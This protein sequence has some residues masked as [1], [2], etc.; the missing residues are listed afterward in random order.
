MENPNNNWKIISALPI[1]LSIGTALIYL[2]YQLNNLGLFLG[3]LAGLAL[4][5]ATWRFSAW[6]WQKPVWPK[7]TAKH[8][9]WLIVYLI[10]WSWAITCLW[11]ARSSDAIIS[12]WLIVSGWFFVAWIATFVTA[13]IMAWHNH[14]LFKLILILEY[15]LA[16][17]V[18]AIIYKLGYGFDPFVHQ[19]AVDYIVKHGAVNP[20][21]FYYSGQYGLETLLTKLGLSLVLIDT[22][23]LPLSSALLLP[24]AILEAG[25]KIFHESTVIR[26][27]PLALLILPY[28][29]L[30]VTTPQNLAYLL[31]LVAIATALGATVKTDWYF[32]WLLT[33]L[34]LLLQPIAGLPLLCL[35]SAWR[36][37]QLNWKNKDIGYG[38]LLAANAVGL[39]LVFMLL[40]V[41]PVSWKMLLKGLFIWDW[42]KLVLPHQNNWLLNIIYSLGNNY[43][44][45]LL[46]LVVIGSYLIFKNGYHRARSLYGLASLHS[47]ALLIAY[48]L[49]RGLNFNYLIDYERN[50]YSSR[51]LVM[52]VI[53]SLP[54]I[55]ISFYELLKRA[56]AITKNPDRQYLFFGA[57]TLLVT[58]SL[59]L[60]YPRQDDYASSG[61]RAVSASDIEAV[62][63][64]AADSG[65]DPYVVLANQQ[66]SAAALRLYGFAHYYND[67]F[68][69]PLPTGGLLYS[70]FLKMNELPS[71]ATAENAMQTAGVNRLYYIVNRYW[72]QSDN[73]NT[74]ATVSA[75]YHFTA[76]N[77]EATIFVY[78]NK[79]SK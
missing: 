14:P 1:S 78:L 40:E 21:T 42:P 37:R 7:L 64:V 75:D 31:A 35:L 23:L 30:I 53:I 67:L 61:G 24:L 18:V 29:F 10:T 57:L 52:A 54:T 66:T 4:W 58:C 41:E 76:Q 47:S 63:L 8:W 72:W 5:L 27:L 6:H 38:L 13:L 20:K 79:A 19:A 28:S 50:N 34:A 36:L 74:L 32:I 26:L 45:I 3:V 9:Y 33:G 25:K 11:Q 16:F 77:G 59:Y 15:L 48:G 65:N 17:S 55:L 44:W 12:P 49:T 68:Y 56:Y 62:K 71:R 69:Y 22:W 39:P 60:A 70:Y 46:I 51:L 2:I 73:L 43:T